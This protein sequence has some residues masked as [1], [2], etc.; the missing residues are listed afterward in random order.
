M[1]E[2]E[3][4]ESHHFDSYSYPTNVGEPPQR[5]SGNATLW[6][7]MN[8]SPLPLNFYG[9]FQSQFLSTEQHPHS[10]PLY[11]SPAHSLTIPPPDVVSRERL[12]L[13]IAVEQRAAAREARNSSPTAQQEPSAK[14]TTPPCRST[15]AATRKPV[16][17]ECP[18]CWEPFHDAQA[19]LFCKTTCGNNFHK[20]CIV[21]WLTAP[22]NRQE[23]LKCPMCRGAWD[24][25]ELKELHQE[26]GISSPRP[27]K[28]FRADAAWAAQRQRQEHI[29]RFT[30]QRAYERRNSAERARATPVAYD[31]R[32][33]FF[34]R[35]EQSPQMSP[36][37]PTSPQNQF[38]S[39]MP[40][41]LPGNSSFTPIPRQ[42]PGLTQSMMPDGGTSFVQMSTISQPAAFGVSQFMP[43]ANNNNSSNN[44][45]RPAQM[46]PFQF[47]PPQA[48]AAFRAQPGPSYP[49]YPAMT[50][51]N[52]Q[53]ANLS[54]SQFGP[55]SH[56]HPQGT[57]TPA[58]PT[59]QHRTLPA[60]QHPCPAMRQH[61]TTMQQQVYPGSFAPQPPSPGSRAS[62]EYHQ[63]HYSQTYTTVY[64][65][66]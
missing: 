2:P 25:Q 36:T 58:T 31:N 5:M 44:G 11:T 28:R 35:D 65:N 1:S 42:T 50:P 23:S 43:N 47:Q 57:R 51:Q 62:W 37:S 29:R 15:G 46:M 14:P 34:V 48:V 54:M 53:T 8:M 19:I 10:G 60:Q 4:P 20:T 24:D 7:S 52:Y 63:Y 13:A 6:A 45:F 22:A 27:A 30:R 26:N 18:V 66:H 59:I 49:R 16:E 33:N 32:P 56:G 40:Y 12:A 55:M 41:Q 38:P 9:G 39:T 61:N 21:E 17:G 3:G 64:M